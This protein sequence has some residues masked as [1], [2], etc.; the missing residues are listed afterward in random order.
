MNK[1]AELVTKQTNQIQIKAYTSRFIMP[2]ILGLV[3]DNVISFLEISANIDL[4]G[5]ALVAIILGVTYS[6]FYIGVKRPKKFIISRKVVKILT[7]SFVVSIIL[8]C[9]AA[10][11]LFI[12]LPTVIIYIIWLSIMIIFVQN[13]KSLPSAKVVPKYI[14]MGVTTVSLGSAV[15]IGAIPT[16]GFAVSEVSDSTDLTI[17][18]YCDTSIEYEP[19]IFISPNGSITRDVPPLTVIVEYME[20]QV[21]ISAF[22]TEQIVFDLPKDIEDIEIKFN[23]Q[24]IKSGNIYRINLMEK[25]HN[26]LFLTCRSE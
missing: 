10:L 18:N 2:F 24:Y 22:Y 9:V 1:T 3:I 21:I 15:S 12:D 17:Y 16:I 4:L 13:P 5:H 25:E 11:I 26:E 20:N 8:I 7:I 23:N 19:G 6:V 14:F